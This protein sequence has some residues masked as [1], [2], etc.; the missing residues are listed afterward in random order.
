MKQYSQACDENREPILAIIRKTFADAHNILEIA[1]GTGQHAVYFAR[2][3]PHL[4]WQPSDLIENHPSIRAWRDDAGLE[5]VLPPIELDVTKNAWPSKQYD[6]LFSA[7]STHIMSWEAVQSMFSG[8]GK[9]LQRDAR[10]CLYGPFN[11]GGTFTSDS[12]KR[13]DD[14]LKQRDPASGIRD[15]EAIAELADANDLELESDNEMP[16]NNRLLVWIKRG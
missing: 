6:G 1:S 7:N 3:L 11:Y 8:I 5:N 10:C 12:N 14:W 16:V 13:F 2:Q 4:T 9:L 15:Y